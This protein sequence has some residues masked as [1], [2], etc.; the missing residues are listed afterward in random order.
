MGKSVFYI[1][2]P[3]QYFNATNIEDFNFKVCIIVDHF[4][5]AKELYNKLLMRKSQWDQVVF[6]QDPKAAYEWMYEHS[7]IDTIYIDSDVGFLK[8]KW[9]YPLRKKQ[10]IV[11][12]EGLGS[13]RSDLRPRKV[14][15]LL[16][17]LFLN[18]FGSKSFFGGS[19]FTKGL[20]LYDH[21]RHQKNIP[22]F[23]GRRINFIKPFL[24]HLSEF[25]DVD[26]FVPK[27][28]DALFQRAE[29]RKVFIYLT[30]WL[31]NSEI[32]SIIDLYP[33][34]F[35]MIK[36]HPHIKEDMSDYANRF[37]VLIP[38]GVLI[39]ILLARFGAIAE[40]VVVAHE[41]SSAMHYFVDNNKFKNLDL[42]VRKND[43]PYIVGLVR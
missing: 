36:P 7:D 31:Y 23:K 16:V 21:N 6:V 8:N 24:A 39:E 38:N 17:E 41:N 26:L 33:D 10:I 9:L 19:V 27:E 30:T 43:H 2:K 42:S 35:K 37:E 28:L 29:G 4:S 12:E 40:E 3:L 22:Q 34:H 15:D 1:S 20:V 25:K 11:Y 18:T 32:D 14:L 13:Y 5:G